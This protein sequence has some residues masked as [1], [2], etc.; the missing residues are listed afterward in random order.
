MAKANGGK[1]MNS[2]EMNNQTAEQQLDNGIDIARIKST[3]VELAAITNEITPAKCTVLL[4][5]LNLTEK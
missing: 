5:R 1:S 2:K 4:H 3:F